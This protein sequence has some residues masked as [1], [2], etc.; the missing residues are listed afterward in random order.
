MSILGSPASEYDEYVANVRK[1]WSHLSNEAWRNGRGAFLRTT[2]ES[3]DIF[4]TP[5]F[6]HTFEPVA[7]ENIARELESLQRL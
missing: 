7:R 6:K 5:E 3:P 4:Y 2:L 1:E